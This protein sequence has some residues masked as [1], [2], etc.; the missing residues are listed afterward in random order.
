[1]PILWRHRATGAYD[2]ALPRSPGWGICDQKAPEYAQE[3]R[4]TEALAVTGWVAVTVTTEEGRHPF[5][6]F[7]ADSFYATD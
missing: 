3:Q 4:W 7:D 2:R 6:I 1:M 5:A